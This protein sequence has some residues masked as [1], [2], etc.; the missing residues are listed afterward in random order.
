QHDLADPV[1]LVEPPGAVAREPPG[2]VGLRRR[3][4]GHGPTLPAS[5]QD[6]HQ[7]PALGPSARVRPVGGPMCPAPPAPSVQVMDSDQATTRTGR[8]NPS[9]RSD[10]PR[11]AIVTGAARGLGRARATGLA[12]A[13]HPLIIDAR[14]GAELETARAAIQN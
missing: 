5:G 6:A 7:P 11:T 12:A 14:D 13:G 8:P 2:A 3:F 9:E 1:Q 4:C 10:R